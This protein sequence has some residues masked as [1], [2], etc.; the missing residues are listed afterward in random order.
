VELRSKFKL[1]Q[2]RIEDLA[3][4]GPKR[5][6]PYSVFSVVKPPSKAYALAN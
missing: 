4:I 3:Q 6:G 5:G 2:C 1:R